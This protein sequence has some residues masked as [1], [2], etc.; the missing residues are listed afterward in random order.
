MDAVL[1]EKRLEHWKRVPELPT[2]LSGPSI[3]DRPLPASA[4]HRDGAAGAP[5]GARA[6]RDEEAAWAAFRK[7][8]LRDFWHVYPEAETWIF[9]VWTAFL[10]PVLP[11]YLRGIDNLAEV[12]R[13]SPRLNPEPP[14]PEQLSRLIRAEARRLGLTAVGSRTTTRATSTTSTSAI[15]T[16]AA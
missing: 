5:H 1:S 2:A 10:A 3:A 4:L 12:G 11:R 15:T 6:M 7:A 9:K 8:P 13:P 14:S 16:P